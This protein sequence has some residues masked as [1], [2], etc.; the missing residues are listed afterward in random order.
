MWRRQQVSSAAS[1]CRSP[2]S[3][4]QAIWVARQ[5]RTGTHL[6]MRNAVKFEFRSMKRTHR[7]RRR[8]VMLVSRDLILP[9]VC[10]QLVGRIVLAVLCAVGRS[11]VYSNICLISS[12]TK[13]LR[14]K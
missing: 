6:H 4:G 3:S 8:S 7:F 13:I 12:E 10:G 14:W 5:H 11:W 9:V 1:L 2:A